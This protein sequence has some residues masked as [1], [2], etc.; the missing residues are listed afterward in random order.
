MIQRR[1]MG[2]AATTPQSLEE[3]LAHCSEFERE[4]IRKVVDQL[5][6][7]PQATSPSSKYRV[8][9][10]PFFKLALKS[11]QPNQ[12]SSNGSSPA[13]VLFLIHLKG[14]RRTAEQAEAPG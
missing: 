10:T 9:A 14:T 13:R 6:T 3:K 11:Q 1:H 7:F 5:M 12:S 2:K 8:A 4:V